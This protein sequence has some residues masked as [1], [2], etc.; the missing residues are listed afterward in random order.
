MVSDNISDS[1]GGGIRFPSECV[2]L[3]FFVGGDD[4]LCCQC[5]FSSPI[6][7]MDVDGIFP[8]LLELSG[9]YQATFTAG[10]Q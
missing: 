10:Q 8:R 4:D 2:K 3:T 9:L 5:N 7:N 1:A 6:L